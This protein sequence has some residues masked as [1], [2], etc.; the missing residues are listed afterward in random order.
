MLAVAQQLQPSIEWRQGMAESLPYEDNSFD[1]VVSQFG[2]MFFQDRSASLSEMLRVL[3]PNATMA[4]AV[5]ESLQR[6]TSLPTFS[7]NA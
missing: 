3:K 1:A 4:V 7:C 6:I 2:L 5:W